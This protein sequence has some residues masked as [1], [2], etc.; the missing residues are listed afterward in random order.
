MKPLNPHQ[1]CFVA[2][3]FREVDRLLQSALR[4]ARGDISPLADDLYDLSPSEVDEIEGFFTDLRR[5][6]VAAFEELELPRPKPSV[7]VRGSLLTTLI[8]AEIALEEICP[9]NLHGYGALEPQAA[10]SL[11]SIVARLRLELSRGMALARRG[12]RA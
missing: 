9:D 8:M 5:A 6:L 2:A 4:L 7:S 11:A 3:V 10:Q 1:C 12:N